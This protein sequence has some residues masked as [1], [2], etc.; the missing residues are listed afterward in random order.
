MHLKLHT[1]C[2]VSVAFSAAPTE[3]LRKKEAVFLSE[4]NGTLSV[5]STLWSATRRL[6]TLLS[7]VLLSSVLFT[8]SEAKRSA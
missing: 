3:D 2:T 4:V 1:Q 6:K 7:S 8:L 5:Q